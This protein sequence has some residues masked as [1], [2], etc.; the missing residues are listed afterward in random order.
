[1]S[2]K[3]QLWGEIVARN[4]RI[5]TSPYFTPRGIK[6][7]FDAVYDRAFDHGVLAVK[8]EPEKVAGSYSVEN[9]FATFF[10]G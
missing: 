8:P 6:Q 4:P 9:L 3:E 2:K 10:K 7:L 5:V 1:M